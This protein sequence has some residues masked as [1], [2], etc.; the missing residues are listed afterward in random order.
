[1]IVG[2]VYFWTTYY[3]HHLPL[4]ALAVAL[5]ALPLAFPQACRAHRRWFVGYWIVSSAV[6][7]VLDVATGVPGGMADFRKAQYKAG[8]M[9]L[10]TPEYVYDDVCGSYAYLPFSGLLF[11]P[12]GIFARDTASLLYTII[13]R[14]TVLGMTYALARF[15]HVR[16]WKLWLL[17]ILI[18]FNGP[19]DRILWLGNSTHF[20]LLLLIGAVYALHT[21]RWVLAGVAFGLAPL[22]KLSMGLLVVYF[23]LR[24]N[25]RVV[26]AWA[27]TLTTCIVLSYA[28]WGVDL[29]TKWLDTCIFQFRGG[30][31]PAFRAQSIDG[32]LAKHYLPDTNINDWTAVP[33]DATFTFLHYLGV[34]LVMGPAVLAAT[35][36]RSRTEPGTTY[37][38]VCIFIFA[39]IL[40]SPISWSHY[41]L[42][43]LLPVAFYAGERFPRRTWSPRVHLAITAM[44]V[45]AV[46]FSSISEEISVEYYDSFDEEDPFARLFLSHFFFG[47]VLFYLFLLVQRFTATPPPDSPGPT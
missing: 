47:G 18:A 26:A 6:L 42:F 24:R 44:F 3:T 1:M 40:I 12:F 10:T 17:L 8:S 28:I 32:F 14:L 20:I 41:Y 21:R 43:L 33:V 7:V 38:E 46:V 30:A 39:A 5:G 16:D 22:L 2:L 45:I 35:S 15:F 11:V 19:L 4:N 31:I 29:N 34:L 27:G 25:W 36:R 9:L 37:L 13:G 23:V